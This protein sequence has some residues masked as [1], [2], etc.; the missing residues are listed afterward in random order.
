MKIATVE[1]VKNVRPHPNAEK[2]DIV[3]IC[4]WQVVV[5]K[6][7][8]SEGSLC[9]YVTVDSVLEDLPV[10][11]FLRNKQFRI[12]TIKLRG[13]LSQGI[14]FPIDLLKSFDIVEIPVEGTEV[15]ELI[16]VQHYEKPMSAQ[17]AGNAKG[18]R[19]FFIKKTDEENIK[20]NP[21]IL[22]EL[23]NKPYYISVKI[24][25]SSGTYYIKDNI[26]G[27]CSRNLELTKD[28]NN[29]FWKIAIEYNIENKLK[30]Y[31]PSKNVAIQG[32][33]YGPGVQDNLLQVDKIS[34]AMFNIWDIDNQVYLGMNDLV[35]F[36][37]KMNI[38]IVP[39]IE[40]GDAC[41]HT[42]DT[43]REISNNLKYPNGNLAEGIVIRPIHANINFNSKVSGRISGKV[44]SENFELKH[45]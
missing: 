30:S 2:L 16:K 7:E 35:E 5:K 4:G 43:L 21:D 31:F 38:P 42:L 40:T 25:G 37:S 14:A 23:Y 15:S 39:I 10:Y 18:Y 9:V 32:E 44:I 17:L 6:N 45:S 1:R 34:F 27:V 26:F 36:G 20:S 3:N 29:S 22:T 33:L 24:D 8:F 13:M 28:E 41:K 11:E 19:P 12:K